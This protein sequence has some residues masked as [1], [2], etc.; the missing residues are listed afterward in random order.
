M[1]SNLDVLTNSKNYLKLNK[2]EK[3]S[4]NVILVRYLE[5]VGERGEET[6]NHILEN[7]F[8]RNGIAAN[9]YFQS[10]PIFPLVKIWEKHHHS[11][12][13]KD[14]VKIK[15]IGEFKQVSRH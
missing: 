11:L 3:D 10:Y 9:Q 6:V 2:I 8:C 7:Y 14:F 4:L 15:S 13:I 1:Q 5:L 12:N